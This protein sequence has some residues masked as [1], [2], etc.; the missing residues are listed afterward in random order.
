M[1]ESGERANKHRRGLVL[2]NTGDGKGKTTA[3]IGTACRAL[4]HGMRVAVIQFIKSESPVGERKIV[5]R[6]DNLTWLTMG[7]G[8][9]V[10]R[11]ETPDDVVAARAAWDK[12]REFLRDEKLDLL[13]L[14]EILYAIGLKFLSAAEVC[15]QLR[16][17]SPSQHVIL[18]GRG[19]P[20]E[21]IGIAD[22]VTE[23]RSI[24]HPFEK[25]E[26]GYVGVDF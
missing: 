19:A 6:I 2:V 18:T 17:R 21:L 11:G 15:D 26:K 3:A 8:C 20:P 25:G 4:S 7:L 16:K 13:I 12:A 10:H 9:T 1:T 22:Q 5:E 23:M 14:D 24:K